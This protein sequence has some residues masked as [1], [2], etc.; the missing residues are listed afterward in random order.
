L[1]DD[2]RAQGYEVAYFSAQDES[3][4]G[5]E[6]DVGFA[7][8]D[9]SYDA[10][11]DVDR[12]Y[13]T[14][15][16]PGSLAVPAEVVTERVT[17]FLRERRRDQPLFLVLNIQDTHFPYRH[18]TIRPVVSDV[19]LDRFQIAPARADALRAMYLNT[20]RNVDDAIAIALDE[21]RASLGREP[22]VIVLSD[23]GESLYDEGFLGHGYALNDAQTRIPLIVANLPI[24]IEEP[25]G[26]SELRD[27]I[28][29]AFVTAAPGAGAQLRQ[30]AAKSIF[31]YLGSV[32]R[33][34]QIALTS[35][36]GQMAYDFRSGRVQ[37]DRVGWR[38]PDA[39]DPDEFSRW[40][41]LVHHWELMVLARSQR[42]PS[43]PR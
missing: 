1:I 30:N 18:A 8:A 21:A 34:V 6:F 23:H 26:Q 9:V 11:Q 4:G 35:I 25:F 16:T 3:F 19:A 12:R 13:T 37:V 40:R 5:A 31:Q 42:A 29:H 2:F 39:L 7:R 32:Q 10:R 14:F 36:T 15:T 17:A 27:A 28:A 24:V 20:T 43:P 38:R 22:G 41:Q 33:P